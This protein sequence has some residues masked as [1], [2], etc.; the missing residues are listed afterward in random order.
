MPHVAG[1]VRDLEQAEWLKERFNESG[2]FDEIKIVPYEVL[3]SYPQPDAVNE[4]SVMNGSETIF[5]T[6]DRQPPLRP[7][8]EESS[9]EVLANFNAYSSPGVVKVGKTC[10]SRHENDVL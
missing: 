6:V 3:L 2:L 8:S 4:V 9:D 10:T 5:R 1:T 7:S